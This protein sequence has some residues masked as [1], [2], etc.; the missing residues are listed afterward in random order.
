MRQA[1]AI[2]WLSI[3]LITILAFCAKEPTGSGPTTFIG[4]KVFNDHDTTPIADA[5]VIA[6]NGNT[7]EPISRS[8]TAADGSYLL[9]LPDSLIG[10]A[11]YLKVTAQ[12]FISS[13]PPEGA[14]IP[15]QPVWHDTLEKAVPLRA[16]PATASLSRISGTVLLGSSGFSDGLVVASGQGTTVSSSGVS[17]P[18]GYFVIYNLQPGTYSIRCYRAG[19]VQDTAAVSVTVSAQTAIANVNIHMIAGARGSLSGMITFLATANPN[20]IDIDVTLINPLTRDVVPGLSTLL[21]D[22]SRQY[23][24]RLI[25]PGTYIAW[26]SYRNDGYVMDPDWIRKSG[27]PT[28]TFTAADTAKTVDFSLTDAITV[29]SPTN[30]ADTVYACSISTVKPTFRWES[31]PGAHEYI[32]EVNDIHGNLV[33]GGFDTAGVIRHAQIDSRATSAEFNFD[34]SARENLQ[35]GQTY[36]WKVYADNDAA[37]NVQGLLSSSEDLRGLFMVVGQ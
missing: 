12:G 24:L 25:P 26:A 30:P 7:N 33:W 28:V 23:Q 20:G 17:G 36:R 6:Y 9:A 29:L 3:A 2:S 19:Y 16:D 31:Y 1:R 27:L 14:P 5:N 13:P 10:T 15:F 18:D 34:N 11:F 35:V 4:G 32:I 22:A 37:A 8:L 21:D